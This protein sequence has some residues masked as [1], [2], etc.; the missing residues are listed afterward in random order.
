MLTAGGGAANEKW[1]VIRGGKL[2][3]PVSAA[4]QGEAAYGSALLARCSG[5]F[6]EL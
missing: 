2:G 5:R 3:V 6:D 1:T 4:T